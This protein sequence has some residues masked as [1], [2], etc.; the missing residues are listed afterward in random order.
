[1][2]PVEPFDV[3]NTL[4]YT[5]DTV[6]LTRPDGTS[7]TYTLQRLIGEGTNGRV[8]LYSSQQGDGQIVVKHL[9]RDDPEVAIAQLLETNT[10]CNVVAM[11]SITQGP[12]VRVVMERMDGDLHR[13]RVEMGN[14]VKMG[15]RKIV[16]VVQ[17][18]HAQLR[19]LATLPAGMRPLYYTNL[20][21]PNILYRTHAGQFT[22]RLGDLGSAWAWEKGYH[23]SLPFWY[24][25]APWKYREQFYWLQSPDDARACVVYQLAHLAWR[26][27]GNEPIQDE[28][29]RTSA[30]KTLSREFALEPYADWLLLEPDVVDRFWGERECLKHRRTPSATRLETRRQKMTR[31]MFTLTNRLD[32]WLSRVVHL[33]LSRWK[34]RTY[35]RHPEP[36]TSLVVRYTCPADS[37]KYPS[38]SIAVKQ[39]KSDSREWKIVEQLQADTECGVVPARLILRRGLPESVDYV[40][41]EWMDN[42]L[43]RLAMAPSL[44]VVRMVQQLRNQLS[45]L[46]RIKI[47]GVPIY[48]TGLAAANV[49][50]HG[51]D[52]EPTVRLGL[53]GTGCSAGGVQVSSYPFWYTDRPWKTTKEFYQISRDHMAD[54]V[55][56]QL[57]HLICGLC[58]QRTIQITGDRSSDAP[59]AALQRAQAERTECVELLHSEFPGQPYAG[60]LSLDPTAISEFWAKPK[61]TYTYFDRRGSVVPPSAPDSVR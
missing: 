54:C 29:T 50:Y 34:T 49:W 61:P 33:H 44:R 41:M 21:S 5:S 19:C 11:R 32:L 15:H 31:Q 18:L 39:V 30:A 8:Y 59:P 37:N 7:Q 45:H 57:A 53:G 58:F 56:Y 51:D 35:D 42:N 23:T 14:T 6:T 24:M 47:D 20:T 22:V 38:H 3:R 12:T 46:S 2:P 17:Q 55:V 28:D 52:G 43:T 16:S 40:A 4:Q 9:R 27:L 48:Y 26:L 10:Q 36:G 1:M 60:W 25:G 13:Y